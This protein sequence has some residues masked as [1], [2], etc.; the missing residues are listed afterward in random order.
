M[1]KFL[2]VWDVKELLKEKDPEKRQE[3]AD[4]IVEEIGCQIERVKLEEPVYKEGDCSGLARVCVVCGRYVRLAGTGLLYIQSLHIGGH[5]ACGQCRNNHENK[6]LT[7][8][9]LRIL[10]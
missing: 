3:I 6:R 4:R 5:F 1:K 9:P 8:S 7:S 10:E 2:G